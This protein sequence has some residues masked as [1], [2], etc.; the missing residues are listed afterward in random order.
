MNEEQILY[1]RITIP[2]GSKRSRTGTYPPR[3]ASPT[4]IAR[5]IPLFMSPPAFP[6]AQAIR[7][8]TAGYTPDAAII[9][10]AYQ[11]PGLTVEQAMMYPTMETA[12]PPTTN[13]PRTFILSE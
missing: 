4:I 6:P 13:G 12:A 9:A 7:T 3:F 5:T 8:A 1:P 10:A 2:F 11:N